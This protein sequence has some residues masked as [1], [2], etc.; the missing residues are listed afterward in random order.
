MFLLII[1][2]GYILVAA[3]M[4]YIILRDRKIPAHYLGRH[5]RLAAI[6]AAV[7]ILGIITALYSTLIEPFTL[8]LNKIEIS[9]QKISQSVRIAFVSDIQI[10]KYKK[11][12]WA[13]KI[14][15]KIESANPDI[16]IFGGDQ[17][18]NE[19]TFEDESKYLEPL[20]KLTEKYPVYYILGNHEYGIGGK[21]RFSPYKYTGDRSQLEIDRMK[22][23]N[24]SLL[25]NQLDCLEINKQ[26]ICLFGLDEIWKY[27]PDFSQLKY[28]DKETPLVL[29][30]HNPDGILYYPTNLPTPALVLSGHTHGGQIWLPLLGP[31]GNAQT[32]L[33]DKY[34]RGLNYYNNIPIFTS[35]GAG[36]S[37]AP[38]RL[39]AMPEVAIITILP[40]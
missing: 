8:R 34:D 22:S 23:L 28:W 11:E 9:S 3:I 15:A 39:F 29:I 26:K 25:R 20:K 38:L 30:S 6:F 19:G 33:E 37:G 7:L 18:D 17:I 12:S 4:I 27:T 35:V 40:Q 32:T 24:I 10:G 31:L 36:E 21:V 13:E 5:R 14:T 2:Y 16:V 1:V